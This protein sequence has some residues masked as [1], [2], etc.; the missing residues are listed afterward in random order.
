MF[1]ID[2]LSEV[3]AIDLLLEDPHVDLII[4]LIFCQHIPA[5][6]LGD[7]RSP[8]SRANDGHFFLVLQTAVA[9]DAMTEP[10]ARSVAWSSGMFGCRA[11]KL[12]V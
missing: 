5:N 2:D 11:D 12:S 1:G 7:G 9:T 8:I 10:H 6:N 3:A 4:K